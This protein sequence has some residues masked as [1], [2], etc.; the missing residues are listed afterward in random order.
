MENQ[1]AL[2][3]AYRPARGTVART[4]LQAPTLALL[5][6]VA[7]A[8]ITGREVLDGLA[9]PVLFVANHASHLD[10]PALLHALPGPWRRRVAVA[11][12]ADYFFTNPW[13]G[14]SVSVLFN[15][16][17][18]ARTTGV[19]ATLR[20]CAGLVEQGWSI[21]L[22]PEGTR[23]ATGQIGPFRP[24]VGLLAVTL[25]IPV[26]P[27]RTVGLFAV[28]PRGEHIPHPGRVQIHF[29][30]PLCF[31]PG[32]PAH[33]AAIAIEAAVCALPACAAPPVGTRAVLTPLTLL[34]GASHVGYL[35][36]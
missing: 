17:P 10:T 35:P 21:L 29:G 5:D 18:F 26:V 11:A 22:Y 19:R 33:A 15:A 9:G 24:G 30:A 8:A 2:L 14:T 32:T 13:R 7:P 25:G 27:I 12:A 20:T 23:S 34:K 6:L 3:P 4:L 31:P 28:L 1:P 16:F 36:Y